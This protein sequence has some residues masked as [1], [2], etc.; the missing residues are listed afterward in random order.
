MSQIFGEFIEKDTNQ[1]EYLQIGFSPSSIS[2]QERWRNNGLSAD[3]LADY[4][5][6]FF[7]GDDDASSERRTEL[8]SAVSYVANEL[9]ENAM[10]FSYAPAQH[11]VSIT[12]QLDTESVRF[13]VRN[14]LDP[15]A[16]PGFQ[17][18]VQEL[19][20]SDPE[21]LYIERVLQNAE[22]ESGG[23]S[24]LGFLTMLNDY[25]AKLGWKFERI[26]LPASTTATPVMT[27]TTM[28]QLT[29]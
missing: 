18:F 23:E 28:V 19:L 6:T 16:L 22:G 14:S 26:D 24:G 25:H 12:M 1:Q 15:Q 8:K 13:Y 20:T 27:V 9:L 11:A 4:L 17:R 21:E 10:K 29:I 7:P 5:S 3:F 2:L